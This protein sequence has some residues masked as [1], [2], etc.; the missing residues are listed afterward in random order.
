MKPLVRK[1]YAQVNMELWLVFSLFV[2]A[3]VL[4]FVLSADHILLGLYALPTLFAAYNYGRTRA[5]LTAIAS[6]LMVV[7]LALWNPQLLSFKTNGFPAQK[8]F[9]VAAWG[10]ILIVTGYAM[11]TLYERQR[12]NFLELRRAYHGVLMILNHFVAKD[13]YTQ[14]HS[15]RVSIYA[16]RIAAE[17][18]F[19][20]ERL[21]D[22]RAAALLHD[23]GKL[24]VSRE[25]LY[26]AAKLTDDEFVEVQSH[27]DKGVK[28]L[29][30]VGGA[31][32]RIIPIILAHHDKFDGSGMHSMAGEDIPLEARI[33]AVADAYDAITSDRPYRKAMSTFE[34]KEIISGLSGKNFDPNVVSAFLRA[35]DKNYMEVPEVML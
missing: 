21:E 29:L 6:T 33:L 18:D 13:K 26:K 5:V 23:I 31:L 24:D 22:I 10:G 19:D 28:I 7:L 8:W 35:F 32:S 20:D 34:A 12:R 1:S 3:G 17:L 30:P 25:I 4:N 15:Y 27:V 11:G 14:N 2:L 16:M 9:D